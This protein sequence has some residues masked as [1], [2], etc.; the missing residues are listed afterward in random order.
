M[1]ESDIKSINSLK[2]H[3]DNFDERYHQ[4]NRFR[5]IYLK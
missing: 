5:I 1:L 4:D 2:N 3:K